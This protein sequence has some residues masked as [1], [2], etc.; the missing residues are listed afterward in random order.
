[1]VLLSKCEGPV[2]ASFQFQNPAGTGINRKCDFPY[3][4]ETDSGRASRHFR[5]VPNCRRTPRQATDCYLSSLSWTIQKRSVR[6]AVCGD[7]L[8]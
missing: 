1:M 4:P 2:A 7:N 6:W 5:F 8:P 3:M